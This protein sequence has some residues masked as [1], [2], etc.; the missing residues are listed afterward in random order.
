MNI[1]R[2]IKKFRIQALDFDCSFCLT[3]IDYSGLISA[4]PTNDQYLSEERTGAKF[5]NDSLKTEGVVRTTDRRTWLD[6]VMMS[7]STFSSGCY[8]LRGKLNT[9]CSGYNYIIKFTYLWR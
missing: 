9:P 5:Q 4:V 6:Q 3:A 7:C 2:Q 1:P 8:K